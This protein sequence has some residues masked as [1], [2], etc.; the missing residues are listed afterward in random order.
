MWIFSSSNHTR[1]PVAGRIRVSSTQRFYKSRNYIVMIVAV[2]VVKDNFFLNGFFGG[3]FR[4]IDFCSVF[5][6]WRLHKR[7]PFFG[8][9]FY[10]QLQGIQK[11][12]GVSI[13]CFNKMF[14]CSFFK[15]NFP[16]S[17]AAFFIM[18]CLLGCLHQIIICKRFE[19][20][21]P[22]TGNESF[23]DFKKRIFGSSPYKDDCTIFYPGEKGVLLRFIPAVNFVYK[24]DCAA[25]V[26]I[27]IIICLLYCITNILNTG[28][29]GI[30]C[31][32]V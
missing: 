9:S 32:K 18:N 26:E 2:P 4:Y 21:N 14:Q 8:S 24:K 15:L 30:Q 7:S 13:C 28:K 29:N 27:V 3:F 17:V 10:S 16:V 22:G 12:T 20:K 1:K 11:G 6:N 23:V 19:L 5:R 31:K 25:G